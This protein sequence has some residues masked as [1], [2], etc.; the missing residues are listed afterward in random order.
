M[1]YFRNF[2]DVITESPLPEIRHSRL[3]L[4]VVLLVV[5]FLHAFVPCLA[6]PK[7]RR[8]QSLADLREAREISAWG[9]I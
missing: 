7:A 9:Q 5:V 8:H 2:N 4:L 3:V 1:E 6:S